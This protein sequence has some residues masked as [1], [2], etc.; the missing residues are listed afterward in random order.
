M[1][2]RR[3]TLTEWR[4]TLT[5]G[6]SVLNFFKRCISFSNTLRLVILKRLSLN[7]WLNQIF[8]PLVENTACEAPVGK[9]T[10]YQML[11]ELVS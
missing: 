11:H 9:T 8:L 5:E 6:V 2:V 3:P 10:H 7:F 1:L 4:P